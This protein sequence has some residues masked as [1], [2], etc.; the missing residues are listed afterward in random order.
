MIVRQRSKHGSSTAEFPLT[1]GIFLLIMLFP[2]INLVSFACG[3]STAYLC[4]HMASHQAACATTFPNALNG[5][6]QQAIGISQS[7]LGQFAHLVPVGGM[8]GSGMN[9]YLYAVD[10]QNGS[11]TIYGPNSPLSPPVDTATKIYEAEAR[12]MYDVGPFLNCA[13][14]PYVADIPLI[15]K[16]AR[17][18]FVNRAAVEHPEGLVGNAVVSFAGPGAATGGAAAA[19]GNGNQP[20]GLPQVTGSYTMGNSSGWNYPGVLTY[21]YFVADPNN[22][23]GGYLI[24]IIATPVFHQ[25]GAVD[26]GV[27]FN[28]QITGQ[29]LTSQNNPPGTVLANQDV[30]SYLNAQGNQAYY[31]SDPGQNFQMN[32][33]PHIQTGTLAAGSSPVIF[34]NGGAAPNSPW[35]TVAGV[36]ANYIAFGP[37]GNGSTQDIS[38]GVQSAATAAATGFSTWAASMGF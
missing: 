19:G 1:L 7:G 38:A 11:S 21:S 25:S 20:S 5:A 18:S 4:A 8:A 24:N 36:F 16:P 13:A 30:Y 33:N 31:I 15:G 17:V 34:G 9:L 6:V 22:S 12:V 28:T 14:V 26:D 23:A 2:M 37:D 32:I 27:T 10:Y 3:C 29:Y 35:G